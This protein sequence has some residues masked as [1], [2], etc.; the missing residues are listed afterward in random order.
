MP[1]GNPNHDALG[2]FSHSQASGGHAD[3]HH[4]RRQ[5]SERVAHIEKRRKEASRQSQ[6]AFARG[7]RAEGQRLNHKA[8]MIKNEQYVLPHGKAARKVST[9]NPARH[10]ELARQGRLPKQQ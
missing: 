7:D 1:K 9:R 5:E 8:A 3:R 2:R 10:T 4:A 6:D